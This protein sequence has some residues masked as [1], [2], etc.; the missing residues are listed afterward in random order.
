MTEV[1]SSSTVELRAGAPAASAAPRTTLEPLPATATRIHLT[2]S[3]E[4]VAL[5]RK[6]KVGQSHV[7][8]G[9]TDERVLTAALELLLEK[10]ARR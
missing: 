2:V 1:R 9:A 10:Q 4:F 6:A 5:L 7:Q 3:P 8:P